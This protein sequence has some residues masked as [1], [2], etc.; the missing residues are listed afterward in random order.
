MISKDDLNC[1]FPEHNISENMLSR[2]FRETQ[3]QSLISRWLYFV[4]KTRNAR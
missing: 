3:S 2:L 4:W 1:N